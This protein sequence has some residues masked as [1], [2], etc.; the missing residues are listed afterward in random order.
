PVMHTETNL[1]DADQAPRWL[2]KEFFNVRYLREQGVPVIGFTWYS[3]LDQ[4]DWDTA[5]ALDRGVVNPCGLY[6]LKRQP[7]PVAEAYKEMIRQFG[8]EPLL[9]R[10]AVF[11]FH[12]GDALPPPEPPALPRP[13]PQHAVD[14]R[15]PLPER[16]AVAI[17]P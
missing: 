13:K 8:P 4:V 2:W 9:P 10:S 14:Q 12:Q 16:A 6:D 3:L 1:R 11:M 17:A 15:P 5:L 7:H